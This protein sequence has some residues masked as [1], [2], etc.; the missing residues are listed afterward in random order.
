MFRSLVHPLVI[1]AGGLLADGFVD[2]EAPTAPGNLAASAVTATTL[3]LSWDPATDNVAVLNYEVE[4]RLSVGPGAWGWIATVAHPTATV[5]V[6]GLTEATSYDFRVRAVDAAGNQSAWTT[7]SNVV[8]LDVTAP[9]VPGNL[10]ASSITATTLTLSWTASTDNVAVTQYEVQQR[11]AS[12]VNGDY[13]T[14]ATVAAP[15]VTLAVTGLTLAERYRF[16]VRARDAAG[17]VSAW[18]PDDTGLLVDMFVFVAPAPDGEVYVFTPDGAGGGYIGGIFLNITDANGTHA[19]ARLAHVDYRGLVTSWNPGSDQAVTDVAIVDAD[20]VVVGKAYSATL[21]DNTLGGFDCRGFGLVHRGTG[22]AMS[23]DPGVVNSVTGVAVDS[24]RVFRTTTATSSSIRSHTVATRLLDSWNPT[25]GAATH[26]VTVDGADII[27]GFNGSR[28]IGGAGGITRVKF[29]RMSKTVGTLGGVAAFN[30]QILSNTFEGYASTLVGADK[31]LLCGYNITS[32]GAQAVKGAALCNRNTG[33]ADAWSLT[34]T[35]DDIERHAAAFDRIIAHSAGDSLRIYNLTSG[36][37]EL[38]AITVTGMSSYSN[39]IY[40]R[41][42]WM[43]RADR[44]LVYGS[45]TA[46]GSRVVNGTSR[47]FVIDVP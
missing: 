14:I 8:T 15:T 12:G 22:V 46:L 47:M 18:G 32:S 13:V 39:L 29:G 6:T 30:A 26:H 27:V 41:K 11:L 28:L 3:T 44:C 36:G 7:L 4:Q 35:S 45:M 20:Y 19:R 23:W 2:R 42:Y 17:N 38:A 24:G 34:R 16:R 10:A 25:L 43:P 1:G 40:G 37:S 21:A 31:I 33:V 9:T 5:N